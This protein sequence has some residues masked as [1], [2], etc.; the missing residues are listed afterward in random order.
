MQRSEVIQRILA[1]R[2]ALAALGVSGISIFGSV[3]RNEA[4]PDS[5]LD[6]IVDSADGRAPGLFRLSRI[7]DE[8]ERVVGSPVDVIS[9]HGLDHAAGLK[10]RIKGDLVRVY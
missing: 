7:T 1:N 6:V 5:D 10:K 3:A 2:Q 9:R 8:L 4:R